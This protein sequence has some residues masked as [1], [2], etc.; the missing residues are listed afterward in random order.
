MTEPLRI[1]VEIAREAQEI[2]QFDRL[3][4][5]SIAADKRVK[6]L[7]EAL[8]L[9]RRMLASTVDLRPD[10]I[11]AREALAAADAALKDAGVE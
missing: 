11:G 1:S 6:P 5:L 7:V 10:W 8:R 9:S 3:L 4:S 2:M